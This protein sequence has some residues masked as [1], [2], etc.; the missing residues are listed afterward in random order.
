MLDEYVLG[1]FILG[2]LVRECT[3]ARR[4]AGSGQLAQ[5]ILR[6]CLLMLL[7]LSRTAAN[8]VDYVRT[9][10]IALLLWQQH[11]ADLPAAT[12][13][14]EN[15]EANLSRLVKRCKKQESP[16]QFLVLRQRSK[17]TRC[18]RRKKKRSR[19][20][21][22]WRRRK[23]SARRRKT[24]RRRRRP[25]RTKTGGEGSKKE[26]EGSQ[27]GAAG[28]GPCMRHPPAPPPPPPGFER[29]GAGSATSKC[30]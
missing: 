8:R 4:Q 29:C 20:R 12:H 11:Q 14:E 21:R 24:R 28:P 7:A 30:P 5:I 23:R 3:W 10:S 18:Q 6:Q 15:N 13:I 26:G 25:R 27:G 9:I 1:G 17:Y 2:Q 22:R 16:R 19:K